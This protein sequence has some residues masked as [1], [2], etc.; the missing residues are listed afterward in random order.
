MEW[1]EEAALVAATTVAT[2]FGCGAAKVESSL[3]AMRELFILRLA[4]QR[5]VVAIYVA[6]FVALICF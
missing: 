3:L 2:P 4:L 6:T 5:L 1:R